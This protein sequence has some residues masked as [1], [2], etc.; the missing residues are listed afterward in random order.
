MGYVHLLGMAPFSRLGI[1]W[2]LSP[3]VTVPHCFDLNPLKNPALQRYD[4]LER[5]VLQSNIETVNYLKLAVL[6]MSKKLRYQC[7]ALEN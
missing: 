7:T 4:N 1:H 6:R 2:T 5:N 3:S